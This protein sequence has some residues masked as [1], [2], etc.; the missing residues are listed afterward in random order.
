VRKIQ[1]VDTRKLSKEEL[2]EAIEKNKKIYYEY[3]DKEFVTTLI[4]NVLSIIDETY[5]RSVFIGFRDL[6]ERNNPDHPLIYA[7]N[8]SG[9]AFPW[10][11]MV[12]TGG[13]LKKHGYNWRNSVRTLIAPALSEITLMNPYLMKNVWKR[14]GGIDATSLNFETMMHFKDSELL[15]YPEGIAGI[16]K[17]FNRK[18]QLQRFSTSMIRMSLKYK[19]DIIPFTTINGEYINP[20]V[21]SVKWVNRL[22]TKIGIPY[23][24]IGLVTPIILIQP[25]IFYMAFPAKLY[26]VM[27]KRIKPYEMINKPFEEVT[28]E[29]LESISKMIHDEMQ[30]QTN[31]AEE[32]WGKDPYQMK[33]FWK[34]FRRNFS[35]FPFNMPFGWPLVFTEYERQFE[36]YMKTGEKVNL[37]FG[38]FSFFRYLFKNPI[39]ICYFI[40]I[41][42]WIPLLIKGYR[43]TKEEN[44]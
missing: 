31:V 35:K 33:E 17:G 1:K 44:Q 9:M 40:P 36:R 39:V 11:A 2:A 13:L 41:I 15:I 10:D 34:R 30:A 20:Y 32:K 5:F 16:G 27:G 38:R 6:P 43:A 23:I 21:F 19:T 3:L 18:Y 4:D 7:S 29:D 12:F 24:P 42:G 25:W 8:H 22:S 37:S 14:C 28:R 26:Y